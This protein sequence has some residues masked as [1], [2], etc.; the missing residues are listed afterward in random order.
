MLQLPSGASTQSYSS[1]L[2][3]SGFT[4]EGGCQQ[5]PA[6]RRMLCEH[7][8]D[9]KNL[10]PVLICQDKL[11]D[12]SP[13]VQEFPENFT[14][15]RHR[16]TLLAPNTPNRVKLPTLQVNQ[17]PL[18]T[19]SRRSQGIE[20]RRFSVHPALSDFTEQFFIC[21]ELCNNPIC[22][23]HPSA[24]FLQGNLLLLVA[25]GTWIKCFLSCNQL[26]GY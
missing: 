16:E 23:L 25:W 18:K 13:F 21:S 14:A 7:Q 9:T 5:Q 2:F 19:D 11:V 10:P 17:N 6:E 8:G 15:S 1:F 4:G 12:C 26:N 20:N 3:S 24:L 22:V